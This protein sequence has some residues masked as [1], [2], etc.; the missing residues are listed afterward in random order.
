MLLNFKSDLFASLSHLSGL[1]EAQLTDGL[2]LLLGASLLCIVLRSYRKSALLNKK[3]DRLQH[4]LLVANNT[5]I[6]M[7]Q[8][9][10]SLEKKISSPNKTHPH[11][12]KYPGKQA[13]LTVVDTIKSSDSID[14]TVDTRD[15]KVYEKSRQL[16]AQ[17]Y[18][19]EEVIKQSGLS[20]SEVSL[21]KAL[22]Q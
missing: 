17:G 21:M 13:K 18:D 8:Q 19:I 12:A 2:W 16:L 14:Q 7:G 1:S 22:A 15:D 5:A 4:D 6:G 3:I 20:Y 10:L 11:T 9:L